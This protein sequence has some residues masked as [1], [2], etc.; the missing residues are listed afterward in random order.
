MAT[1]SACPRSLDLVAE[2]DDELWEAF[3]SQYHRIGRSLRAET[4]AALFRLAP[5]R[6]LMELGRNARSLLTAPDRHRALS[7][8]RFHRSACHQPGGQS[9]R[10]T[11]TKSQA[12]LADWESRRTA[13]WD[14]VRWPIHFTSSKCKIY[15]V[16][17]NRIRAAANMG[18][19]G[20]PLCC[21]GSPARLPQFPRRAR[22][23]HL[24]RPGRAG[25]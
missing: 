18:C 9:G 12:E 17:A 15:R 22:T 23:G 24:C 4:R 11:I 2:N 21:G 14:F 1:I 5:A 13:D 25:R 19:R 3:V 16:L 8:D 10:D 20:R 6:Q 7:L